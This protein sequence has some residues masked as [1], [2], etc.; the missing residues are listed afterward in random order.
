MALAA[1]SVLSHSRVTFTPFDP[2]LLGGLVLGVRE[3][4]RGVE[5]TANGTTTIAFLPIMLAAAGT[6]AGLTGAVTARAIAGGPPAWL[7]ALV[8]GV[9]GAF[10]ARAVVQQAAAMPV[11]DHE[12]DPRFALQGVPA[13]VVSA[14]P[15]GDGIGQIEV[16]DPDF[17]TQRYAARGLD[18]QAL[19]AGVEVGV[20]RIEDGVAYVEAWS[21]IETRL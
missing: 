7:L 8:A 6:L 1:S 3:L 9:A 16:A 11:E 20:E 5:R 13:R 14:I 10:A 4:A 17:P 21:V 2:I 19:P 15:G 18:G 12:Y